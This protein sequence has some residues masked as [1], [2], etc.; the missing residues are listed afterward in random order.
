VRDLITPQETFVSVHIDE[1]LSLAL[2]R[3]GSEK[4][5]MLPVVSRANSRQL[6]GLVTLPEVLSAYGIGE[7]RR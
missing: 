5:D 4:A 2:E 7:G 1:P 3:M 6:L